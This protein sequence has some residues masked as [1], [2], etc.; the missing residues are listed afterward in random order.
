VNAF[1]H[2]LTI[3]EACIFLSIFYSASS[4]LT[5]RGSDYQYHHADLKSH[6]SGATCV[7][8][9]SQWLTRTLTKH[10]SYWGSP[11]YTL[12]PIVIRQLLTEWWTEHYVPKLTLYSVL[13]TRPASLHPFPDYIPHFNKILVQKFLG[14][15]E[16]RCYLQ[17]SISKKFWHFSLK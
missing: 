5:L 7:S 13:H 3:T 4:T 15:W 17:A 11:Q 14:R 12:P 16:D 2:E 10:T 8:K 9:S 1:T 6:C